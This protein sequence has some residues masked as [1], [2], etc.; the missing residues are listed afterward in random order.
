MSAPEIVCLGGGGAS[1]GVVEVDDAWLV[2]KVAQ[3]T[4]EGVSKA[5][6]MVDICYFSGE[7]ITHIVVSGDV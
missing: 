6:E 2:V 3:A 5:A 1:P 7:K 4:H